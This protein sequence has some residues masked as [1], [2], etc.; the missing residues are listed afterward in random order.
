MTD[1]PRWSTTGGFVFPRY[2]VGVD[3]AQSS[4]YT[5]FS[6]L[7]RKG[8][9]ATYAVRHLER[10]KGQPYTTV[11]RRLADLVGRLLAERPR[12]EVEVVV[13]ATGVGAAAIDVM[14]EANIGE[15]LVPVLIHGGDRVSHEDGT[16]RTPKRDLISA[17]QVAMEAGR[18]R[19][20]PDFAFAT[21]LTD[22]LAKFRRKTTTAGRDTYE[23]WR[24]D[25]HDDAV[26]SV[27]LSVWWGEH[28]N[29][30]GGE[31]VSESWAHVGG[32]DRADAI[33]SIWEAGWPTPYS[34][35]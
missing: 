25:D 14:R 17:V 5:C 18:L 6:F 19:V 2:V 23:A 30:R 9:P 4:D 8:D 10:F 28:T 21:I 20:N 34:R 1:T 12:P 15:P 11:A 35:R 27:A 31:A 16:Y 3:L 33:D 24:E 26:L 22:E 7:E 13:D 29:A 32:Q